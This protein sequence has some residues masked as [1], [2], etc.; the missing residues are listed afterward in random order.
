MTWMTVAEAE[1]WARALLAQIQ[2]RRSELAALAP[3]LSIPGEGTD[4][5]VE[6][7]LEDLVRESPG[8]DERAG[9]RRAA[10][11][12]D[13]L[14]ALAGRADALGRR[15]TFSPCTSRNVIFMRSA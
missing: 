1:I 3:W 11:L 15:W 8:G 13:R 7:N 5:L 4:Q 2:E 6:P 9:F 12:R 10:D 14:L